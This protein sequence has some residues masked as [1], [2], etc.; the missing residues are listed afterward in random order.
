[1][2]NTNQ[3]IKTAAILLSI[4]PWLLGG[5]CIKTN[6]YVL[7]N[8]WLNFLR[9]ILPTNFPN[10]QK[11]PF[12]IELDS[13]VGGVDVSNSITTGNL[14]QKK[15]TQCPFDKD[16]KVVFLA[17]SDFT[18]LNTKQKYDKIIFYEKSEF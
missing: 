9:K 4:D 10:L 8:K 18:L 11:I 13:L 15:G 16:D 1:M 6:D 2:I 12:N 3:E 17:D 7:E 14:I 5:I